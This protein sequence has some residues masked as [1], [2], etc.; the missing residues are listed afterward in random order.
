MKPRF[1]IAYIIA[2]HHKPEM[3]IRLVRHIHSPNHGFFIH[4]NQRSPEQEYLRLVEALRDLPNVHFLDRHKCLWGDIGLV[5]AALKGIQAIAS[6]D[7]EYDYAVLLTGQDYSIKSDNQIV[8]TLSQANG[9]SFMESS[10]W[11]I[12]HWEKGRAIRRIENFHFQ[13]PFPNWMRRYGW[14]PSWQHITLPARRK[15]P[16][17]LHP[18]FGSSF[19]YLSRPC[20]KYIHDYVQQHPEYVRFFKWVSIPDECFFQILL[21]NS[22]LAPT[23]HPRTLTYIDWSR[24]PYPA[25]LNQNDLP[26]LLESDCLFARKFDLTIDASVLDKLDEMHPVSSTID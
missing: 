1:R 25:V 3:T 18:H 2:A 17:S 26:R 6:Q 12:P 8:T 19:W 23:I 22:P 20:L 10:A 21:M 13:L 15:I 5:R 14:P 9:F 11:P 7:F 24:K 16:G 4:Y